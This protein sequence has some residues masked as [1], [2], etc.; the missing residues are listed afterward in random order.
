MLIAGRNLT[1]ICI[2]RIS[3]FIMNAFAYHW[4]TYC[5]INNL[6]AVIFLMH[7]IS[8]PSDLRQLITY[9]KQNQF[10]RLF[11]SRLFSLFLHGFFHSFSLSLFFLYFSFVQNRWHY[12]FRSRI[13]VEYH[14]TI[15]QC[16][17]CTLTDFLC[18]VLL[19]F[20][21]LLFILKIL[22]PFP[23]THN[24]FIQS[25]SHTFVFIRSLSSPYIK[26]FLM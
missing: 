24:S 20:R 11:A 16:H 10:L 18:A 13:H 3:F 15:A 23:H 26:M 8:I 1:L 17:R 7:S 21:V 9:H 6:I 22:F 19:L 12:G 5:T 2:L 4:G 25:Q 14:A